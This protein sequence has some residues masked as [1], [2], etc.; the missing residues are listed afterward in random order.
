MH[1]QI[2]YQASDVYDV[3]CPRKP[4][5]K[6]CAVRVTP[7]LLRWSACR[8]RLVAREE[9]S[10]EFGQ[11]SEEPSGQSCVPNLGETGVV[12]VSASCTRDTLTA[13]RLLES[14]GADLVDDPG[15]VSP[16]AAPPHARSQGRGPLSDLRVRG[17]LMVS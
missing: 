17:A 10:N 16:V 11:T 15:K 8:S 13:L 9:R 1:Y 12:D 4:L 7:D 3:R 5:M 6:T 2:R 14:E